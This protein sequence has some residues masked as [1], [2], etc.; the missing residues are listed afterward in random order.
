MKSFEYKS[1]SPADFRIYEARAHQL[2][3]E[4]IIDGVRWVANFVKSQVVKLG[5]VFSH[6]KHA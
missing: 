6:R 3:A 1:I 5:Q 4:A 2:R